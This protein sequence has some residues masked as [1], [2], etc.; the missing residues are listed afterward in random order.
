MTNTR[1]HECIPWAMTN[2]CTAIMTW[3]TVTIFIRC[4]KSTSM[5]INRIAALRFVCKNCNVCAL[6]SHCI[7]SRDSCLEL[8][9]LVL[10]RLNMEKSWSWLLP[11]VQNKV[12]VYSWTWQKSLSSELVLEKGFDD[13]IAA[14]LRTNVNQKKAGLGSMVTIVIPAWRRN[15]S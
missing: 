12:L 5:I 11:R 7:Y 15:N 10:C 1:M 3:K 9:V 14:V 8:N 6:T 13:N 4:F 2:Y